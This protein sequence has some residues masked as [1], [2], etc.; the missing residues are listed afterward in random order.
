MLRRVDIINS[1]RYY[2]S[3]RDAVG[4]RWWSVKMKDAENEIGQSEK[5]YTSSGLLEC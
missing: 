5:L 3:I 2:R 1:S 4:A